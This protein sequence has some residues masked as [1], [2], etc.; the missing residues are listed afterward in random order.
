[1]RL[2]TPTVEDFLVRLYRV[3]LAAEGAEGVTLY[4]SVGSAR[5]G[6][7]G[8]RPSGALL[9]LADAAGT[10]VPTARSLHPCPPLLGRTR[11]SGGTGVVPAP[12]RLGI[13]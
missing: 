8:A 4:G 13:K 3:P 7:P 2:G 11:P 1:M 12:R 10:T 9:C 6:G 5:D